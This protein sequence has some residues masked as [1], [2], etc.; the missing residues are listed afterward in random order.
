MSDL[1]EIDV[2]DVNDDFISVFRRET[3]SKHKMGG[4]MISDRIDAQNLRF[5]ESEPG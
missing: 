5:R 2:I 4:M 1:F 3:F